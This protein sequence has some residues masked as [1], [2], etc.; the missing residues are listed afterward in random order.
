MFLIALA[1]SLAAVARSTVLFAPYVDTTAGSFDPVAY[2]TQ[3]GASTFT[4]GFVT[5][6]ANAQPQFNGNL[7]A[8]GW[9]QTQVKAIRA[10]GGDIVVAF[11]GAVG[12]ELGNVAT[13][14]SS[15]AAQ[16][17]SVIQA[18]KANYIEFDIE[19]VGLTNQTAVDL[20]NDALK[21]VQAQF[22]NVKMAYTLPTA[23]FG[24]V[25]TGLYVIN[26][27]AKRGLR[28]DCLNLMTMDYFDSSLKYTDAS[29]NSLMGQYAMKAATGAYQQVGSKV[30]SIGIT[31]MIGVNDDPK[32]VFTTTNAQ[33]VA[34]FAVMST[35]VSRVSMW[36][37]NRDTAAGSGSYASTFLSILA[38]P[39]P[40]PPA[41]VT[42]VGCFQDSASLQA[43]AKQLTLASV[44]PAGCYNACATAGYS[45]GGAEFSSQCFCF[46]SLPPKQL[47]ADQCNMPCSGDSSQTCGGSW[48]M[49]VASNGSVPPPPKVTVVGCFQ[50]SATIQASSKQVSLSSVTPESCFNA[51]AAAGYTFGGAEFTSQCFCFNSL[52]PKQLAS[53][54][55]NM[56]CSG[57][58]S[59]TCGGFWAMTVA[60]NG[61]VPPPPKVTVVG[62][63]QDSATIQA[64]L[65]EVSL[66]SVTQESC[67]NACAAAG[68]A[69][70]GAEFTSQCFCFNSLP[71][72]QLSANQCNM[73]CSGDASQTC[74]GSWAMTVVSNGSVP[75]PPQVI[76]VGC[77]QD[78]ASLQ[79]SSKQVSLNSVT[80]ENCLNACVSAGYTFGGAEYS[81]QCF[82]FNS[83]PSKQLASNQC[84]MQCSG[85]ASQV[86][87]GS[88]AMTV[89]SH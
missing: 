32:E 4:L 3:T 47:S 38:P 75:P 60:S 65:K 26:S 61:S 51:C 48:A 74:G 23:T 70:G 64:S 14:A 88:W 24:L 16:Y 85:D 1:S 19:G 34:A 43:S 22:P 50:D 44:T 69:L 42:I 31:P 68:Y 6:D 25:D 73:P 33:E 82:C 35:Y 57:D 87:G 37:A 54:Q 77:F 55:C 89:A 58:S 52:P 13:S 86:C 12:T 80:P 84:N 5:A 20:R 18:Y 79:A 41:T 81:S 76:I 8:N 10:F 56:P 30:G 36:S 59:Q 17:V 40:P 62:C 27:A 2:H 46:N 53:N 72:K 67:Y 7:V 83:L 66:S 11:G 15:L 29:G 63:F 21:L 39:L 71:P 49:T 78:S 45:F 28:V 9:Y